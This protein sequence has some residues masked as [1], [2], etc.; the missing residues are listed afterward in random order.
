[1]GYSKIIVSYLLAKFITPM[2]KQEKRPA[3]NSPTKGEEK[4]GKKKKN[5]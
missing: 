3:T 2:K 4:K 1:L 5:K